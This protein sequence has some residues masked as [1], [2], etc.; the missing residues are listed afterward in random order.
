M[1]EAVGKTEILQL[2]PFQQAVELARP[3]VLF[4]LYVAAAAGWWFVAVPLAVA[5]A[6]AGFV[7]MHDAIHR[8]PGLSK[9]GT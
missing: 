8:S 2:T 5:A 4:L 3:S 9:G 7:Q 1:N 6:L